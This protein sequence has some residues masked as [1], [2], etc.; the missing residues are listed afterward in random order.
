[1]N[2]GGGGV[3]SSEN[4]TVSVTINNV[5]NQSTRSCRNICLNFNVYFTIGSNYE[6]YW[7]PEYYYLS[8]FN[9]GM[10]SF[11]VFW[12]TLLFHIWPPSLYWPEDLKFWKQES[13]DKTTLNMNSSISTHFKNYG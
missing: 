10:V 5:G 2:G 7:D 1:M 11:F 4:K 3:G 13:D 6:E 9:L 8:S 12:G